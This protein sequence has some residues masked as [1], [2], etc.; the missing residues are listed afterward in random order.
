MR[1]R[2]IAAG[3]V[4]VLVVALTAPAAAAS[5]PVSEWV[6]R[7]VLPAG[8][9]WAAEGAG[10]TGGSAATP[11]NVFHVTNRDQLAAAVAGAD[12]AIIFVRGTVHGNADAAG[13]PLSCDQ[14]ADPAYS[15]DAFLAAYDPAVWGRVAPSGPLE[16]ARV[17]SAANQSARVRVNVGSNKTIIGLGDARLN[18]VFLRLDGSSN[19]IIRNLTHEDS[20]DCFPVWSPTDGETGNWNAAYD[21]IW[22]R[23]SHHVWVDHNTFTDADNPDSAQPI[24]FGRPF[25]VHDGQVDITNGSNYVTVS[26]NRF[27]NHDKTMLIGSTNTPG[28]D[29]GALKVTLHHNEYD[30]SV[31]RAPRVRFGQ[32]DVYNNLYRVPVAEPYEYSWGVGVQS[33][34]YAENNYVA[35][36][37]A[38]APEAFVFDWGGTVL[39]E[40]GTWV[41]QGR[42]LPRPASLLAAYNATHDPDLAPDAGWTP[43][44]RAGPV[45]PAPAAALLVELCAGARRLAI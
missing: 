27:T 10:T 43:S 21:N 8:D 16:E 25:Q 1:F 9:G 4:G 45:L 42:S 24:H 29:V 39:T 30:G 17:R 26:W 7:Q 28:A 18:G 19:V 41:R 32:V 44:L 15:L 35:L 38:V 14:F 12:P 2:G 3:A 37:A 33:A 11:E 5:V 36:G 31:Q 22:I 13:A 34:I 40:K 6:G 23:N 20:R